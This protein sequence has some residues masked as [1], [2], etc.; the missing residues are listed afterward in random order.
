MIFM[1]ANASQF[2]VVKT[3]EQILYIRKLSF[4]FNSK[5][6]KKNQRKRYLTK[7]KRHFFKVYSYCDGNSAP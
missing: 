1:H 7:R 2:T 6:E 3:K 4:P 5:I